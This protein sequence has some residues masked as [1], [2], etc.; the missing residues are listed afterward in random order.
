MPRFWYYLP[1]HIVFNVAGLIWFALKG[2]SVPVFKAK[3]HA[4]KEFPR[5]WALRKITQG[6]R[7]VD[8]SVVINKM[9]RNFWCP[10]S[11]GKK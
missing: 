3:W 11:R 8:V 6:E 5:V 9:S 2:K 4:L 7:V 10:Y 1:Q